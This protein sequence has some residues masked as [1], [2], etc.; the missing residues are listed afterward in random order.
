MTDNKSDPN[1]NSDQKVEGLAQC[2]P[3]VQND[4]ENEDVD[5]DE[6]T[7]LDDNEEEEGAFMDMLPEN[8]RQRVEKLKDLHA[9]RENLLLHYQ[10]DRVALEKKYAELYAPLFEKRHQVIIGKLDDEIKEE[11]GSKDK[12]DEQNE[13]NAQETNLVG[14][15]EFWVCAI[16]NLEG[17]SELVTERDNE[18][19]LFLDNIT[20]DENGEGTGFTLKFH[21]RENPFFE[22]KVLTKMYEIPNLLLDDEPILKNVEGCEI[23]WKPGKC[24]THTILKK[25]QKCKTGKKA[26]QVRTIIQK[27]K[28]E[29]FFHF[30][31]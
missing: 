23:K 1:E 10:K 14:V 18:C 22:N 12:S 7:E 26:G 30:F 27:E 25:K 4:V 19:I 8:V 28:Q 9:E 15:P 5:S 31:R 21:F 2:P 11:A 17:V 3:K 29:S 24:L 6:Y 20:C 13:D 16:G